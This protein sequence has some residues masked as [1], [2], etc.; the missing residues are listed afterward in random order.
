VRRTFSI[1][2]AVLVLGLGTL[3]ISCAKE[4]EAV[5]VVHGIRPASAAFSDIH[6]LA[7]EIARMPEE[8]RAAYLKQERPR[9][10]QGLTYFL[11]RNDRLRNNEEIERVEFRFGSLK[12]VTASDGAGIEHRG[13]FKDELVA[14]VFVKG[15]DRPIDVIVECLNGLFILPEQMNTL[16]SLG[17]AVPVE[18]FTIGQ[19]EGL[20]K[21][22]DYAVAIDLA[23]RFDLPLYRG[24]IQDDKFRITPQQARRLESETDRIQVTVH[25]VQGDT[26]D[27]VNMTMNGRQAVQR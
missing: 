4:A 3:H 16:Q 14:R 6:G 15:K 7:E 20:T 1:C 25:V 11:R 5:D 18:R 26:F 22:V 27:L 12:N 21:H 13:Q 2:L 9:L 19:R 24:R 8:R 10:E 17:S 23:D